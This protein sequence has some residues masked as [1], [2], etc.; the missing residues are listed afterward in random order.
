MK[1]T[2]LFA[3]NSRIQVF[4]D[5]EYI[6]SC[7]E[8]FVIKNGLYKD[9]E[10]TVEVLE[11]L[12]NGAQY[13]ILEYK[14]M[15]YVSRGYYS[16]KE[17][18]LKVIRYCQKRFEFTPNDEFF[19][20]IFK[21]LESLQLYSS[22]YSAKMLTQNYISRSKGKNYISS[23]LYSKG[24]DKSDIEE[25]LSPIKE[26]NLDRNLKGVLQRKLKTLDEKK[27]KNKFEIKQKL[28]KFGVGRGFSYGQAKKA[29]DEILN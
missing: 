5:E 6:F 11:E 2:S 17:L 16:K 18:R 22:L 26:E 7:T 27:F 25:S 1:I 8:N 21:K 28:L 20:E 3:K 12:K 14:L 10:V 29:V 4:V 23:K 9:K 19:D 13:S 15:D 24:F